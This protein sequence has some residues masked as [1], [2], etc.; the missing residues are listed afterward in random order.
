MRKKTEFPLTLIGLVHFCFNLNTSIFTYMHFT[1]EQKSE[2]AQL[3]D[4]AEAHLNKNNKRAANALYAALEMLYGAHKSAGTESGAAKDLMEA[5]EQAVGWDAH[6]LADEL[7]IACHNTSQCDRGLEAIDMLTE[8][9]VCS[10]REMI[11]DTSA[12]FAGL[13]RRDKAEEILKTALSHDP[14]DVWLYI[15]LGDVYYHNTPLDEDQD[16]EKAEKWY[17]A[18]YDNEIGKRD[19]ESWNALLERLGSVTVD[20]LRRA[21]EDRLLRAMEQHNIGGYR[22]LEQLKANIAIASYDS[23]I[24]Q[25]MQMRIF[26]AI[27]N[28]TQGD[29]FLR[30]LNDV[31]NLAPQQ[32]L[33]DL[34]AF[35]MVEYMPKGEHELRIMEEMFSAFNE[36]MPETGA[37]SG[38]GALGS[39]AFSDFQV[40]FIEQKDP[41]TGIKRRTLI[42]RERKKTQQAYE[43]GTLVWEGFTRFRNCSSIS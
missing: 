22:T 11:A 13:G 3:G 9:G 7:I 2:L 15:S 12:F 4:I 41:A 33:N 37:E 31:Y 20:R 39:Q 32:D 28:K 42:S 35:E 29:E 24:L 10:M 16:F 17:Y 23:I 40:R 18:A 1:D 8:L 21:A 6:D 25:H 36:Q 14:D 30:L 19:K 5:F 38:F 43:R 26:S 34:S 27:Q